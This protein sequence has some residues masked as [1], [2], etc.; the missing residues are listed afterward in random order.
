[1]ICWILLLIKLTSCVCAGTFVV[2]V[3]QT[4]YQAEENHHITLE[5]TFTTTTHRSLDSVSFLCELI[6][7]QRVSTLYELHDGVESQDEEFSGRVQFDKD[8]LREGRI[9]LHVSRLRTED[10]GR[11]QCGV[12]TNYGR[13]FV[14]CRLNVTAAKNLSEPEELNPP[15][16]GRIGLYVG[17]GLTAAA[18]VVLTVCYCLFSHC[19]PREQD[20]YSE[21]CGGLEESYSSVDGLEETGGI[22]NP[23]FQV[24]SFVFFRM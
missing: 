12:F 20:F 1:M 21:S 19:L 17:L 7:D 3:T 5:W 15:S 2:N 22:E 4:S 14:E 24:L 6:L 8:V 23:G 9:R 11:Y 10:S 16:Q 13:G 18:A